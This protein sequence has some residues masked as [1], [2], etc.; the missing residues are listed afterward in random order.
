ME[1]KHQYNLWYFVLAM[2][3][4]MMLQSLWQAS[5]TIERISYSEFERRLVGGEIASV[6]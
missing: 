4:V 2:F 5:G 1:R 3:A 6:M